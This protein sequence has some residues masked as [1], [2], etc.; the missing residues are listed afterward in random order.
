MATTPQAP[1]D[2]DQW[3]AQH[4]APDPD[5]W[6]A[7]RSNVAA[8]GAPANR[9]PAA[10]TG[11]PDQPSIS[12]TKYPKIKATAQAGVGLGIGAAKQIGEAF[13][14]IANVVAEPEKA[15][16]A[17][18]EAVK[19]F[20][21][22]PSTPTGTMQAPP[23]AGEATMMGA[24][25]KV[26]Q[27]EP[28][29]TIPGKILAAAEQTP[30]LGPHVQRMEAAA[31]PQPTPG[32]SL[33]TQTFVDPREMGEAAGRASAEYAMLRGAPTEKPWG[34]IPN[35]AE[36]TIPASITAGKQTIS[37]PRTASQSG[38]M[39]EASGVEKLLTGVPVVGEPLKAVA[40]EQAQ[41]PEQILSALSQNRTAI[42]GQDVASIFIHDAQ[43]SR[44]AAHP[45]YNSLH[46]VDVSGAGD[47]AQ[48]LLKNPKYSDLLNGTS[49]NSLGRITPPQPPTPMMDQFVQQFVDQGKKWSDL[50][51]VE[52]QSAM[53]RP[54][55]QAWASDPRVQA[56]LNPSAHQVSF[57]DAHQAISDMKDNAA[58]ARRVGDFARAKRIEEARQTLDDAIEQ[59][60]N[61]EQLEDKKEA[62][63][64]WHRSAVQQEFGE[65]LHDMLAGQPS[66]GQRPQLPSSNSY[67]KLV[68]DLDQ[69]H[70]PGQKTTD[71]KT[72]FP[73]PADQQAA[74]QL[75][76][77]LR[78]AEKSAGSPM[79]SRLLMISAMHQ[80]GAGVVAQVSAR[81]LAALGG[82]AM[83]MRAMA[84]ELARPGSMR[85]F[86]TWLKLGS[87]SARGAAAVGDL[88][89]GISNY[90]KQE[91]F[92]QAAP[93]AQ[94]EP[95]PDILNVGGR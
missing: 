32:Q 69:M 94:P 17:A 83:I 76:L 66:V 6:L 1:P 5:E 23:A 56:E 70:T 63:R 15:F 58:D 4:T 30:I 14:P 51:D 80:L 90:L 24:E 9:A 60:L 39:P 43:A 73:N 16:P 45:L 3:L 29:G 50:S 46:P 40:R 78:E 87:A 13:A 89:N 52:K 8:S 42:P 72:L 35:E 71:L 38:I 7:K 18:Y 79:G 67:N 37:I 11:Q 57:Q 34:A 95:V 19:N 28:G 64:L 20:F 49:K 88:T 31:H 81:S 74:K 48:K 33:G 27:V 41:V 84:S 85:N 22:H 82:E 25:P 36:A 61:P 92:R 62:D 93:Q 12:T 65:K 68:N 91:Q 26:T 2:P 75:G 47:A 44:D 10:A 53:S 77:L 54:E 86:V 59:H 55:G 21:T